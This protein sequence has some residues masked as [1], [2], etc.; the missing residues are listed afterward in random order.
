MPVISTDTAARLDIVAKENDDFNLECQMNVP[1]DWSGYVLMMVVKKT[2]QETLPAV[3]T[4]AS[5][6]NPATILLVTGTGGGNSKYILTQPK[7]MMT[8]KSD[9]YVYD[10][11][12]IKNGAAKTW[13]YG[14]FII[15]PKSYVLEYK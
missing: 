14:D 3:L 8:N 2:R 5:N 13:H 15:T 4:F 6:A 9:K 12:G 10:L 7:A 11:W 1:F